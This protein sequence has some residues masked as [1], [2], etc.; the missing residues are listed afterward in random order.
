MN[1]PQT[2]GH[3]ERM[4]FL[5]RRFMARCK[6]FRGPMP[7]VALLNLVLLVIMF[8]V[9]QSSFVL[10]PGVVVSLPSSPFVSG[11]PYSARVVTITQEGLIFFEDEQVPLDKLQSAFAQ[12]VYERPDAPLVIE[13][14]SR[15]QHAVIIRVYNLAMA[16]GVREVL[17]ATRAGSAG[18][19]P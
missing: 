2:P 11:L 6:P 4:R 10:K 7:A 3:D 5:Q 18:V 1:L 9:F 17:L 13:A 15:V 12:M 16:V 19:P 14:D 8:V